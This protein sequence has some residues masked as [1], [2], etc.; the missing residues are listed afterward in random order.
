M[1]WVELRVIYLF[2]RKSIWHGHSRSPDLIHLDFCFWGLGK[3]IILLNLDEWWKWS[4]LLNS[5]GL[6]VSCWQYCRSFP[7]AGVLAWYLCR[8]R[9][10]CGD[11]LKDRERCWV[12][13]SVD[14]NS[15]IYLCY[16]TVRVLEALEMFMFFFKRCVKRIESL[17]CITIDSACPCINYS[18]QKI[19]LFGSNAKPV[20]VLK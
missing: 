18:V 1:W 17:N 12:F 7:R 11:S 8:R 16:M 2:Y 14:E 15:C 4:A 10:T 5:R 19:Q 20:L 6:W 13:A 9:Y 3:D